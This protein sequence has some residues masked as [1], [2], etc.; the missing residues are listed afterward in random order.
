MLKQVPA[1][2]MMAAAPLPSWR[3]LAKAASL[4]AGW[5]GKTLSQGL[6]RY[7]RRVS[8]FGISVLIVYPLDLL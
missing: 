6:R 7:L 4:N 8:V 3:R 1:P 5:A 2:L